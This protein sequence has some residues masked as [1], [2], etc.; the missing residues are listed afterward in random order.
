MIYILIV[1]WMGNGTGTSGKA[2]ITVE[3]NDLPSCRAAAAEIT[4]QSDY[5]FRP[6]TI[7]CAQKGKP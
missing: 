2:A 7:L 1:M 3:F 5:G 4:K 6:S